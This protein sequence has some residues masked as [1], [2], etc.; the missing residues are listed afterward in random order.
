MSFVFR[1]EVGL[2]P[3]LTFDCRLHFGLDR[4]IV[5]CVILVVSFLVGL[6]IGP[7]NQLSLTMNLGTWIFSFSLCLNAIGST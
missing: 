1:F 2:G 7:E 3:F 4:V 5:I 6:R